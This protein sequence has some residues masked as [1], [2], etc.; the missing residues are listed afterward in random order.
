MKSNKN[1]PRAYSPEELAKDLLEYFKKT[2]IWY[3]HKEFD[4]I[5]GPLDGG[6]WIYAVVY[7]PVDFIMLTVKLAR[8]IALQGGT[9]LLINCSVPVEK[10]YE[11]FL[12]FFTRISQKAHSLQGI[13][14]NG[15]CFSFLVPF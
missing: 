1:T 13:V 8:N 10:M 12:T 15:C 2:K 4:E 6:K 7:P 9:V 5:A 14:M 3:G 11:K